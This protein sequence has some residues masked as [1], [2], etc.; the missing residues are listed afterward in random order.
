MRKVKKLIALL[1][2]VSTCFALSAPCFAA[3]NSMINAAALKTTE[4]AGVFETYDG[5]YVMESNGEY[6]LMKK[7]SIALTN[8]VAVNHILQ[9]NDLPTEVKE[10]IREKYDA[11]KEAG[12]TDDVTLT[13]YEDLGL[14]QN[15]NTRGVQDPVY[16]TYNGLE[17]KS[18]VTSWTGRNQPTVKI[19]DGKKAYNSAS[20]LI[21]IAMIGGNFVKEGSKASKILAAFSAGKTLW[22]A[23]KEVNPGI[24]KT[25]ASNDDFVELNFTYDF[26]QKFVYVYSEALDGWQHALDAEKAVIKNPYIRACYVDD[27]GY[28]GGSKVLQII[29]KVVTWESESYSDPW[30]TAHNHMFFKLIEQL[31]ATVGDYKFVFGD[32]RW[33]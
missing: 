20:T 26:Y 11:L 27:S 14:Y 7:S 9:N 15:A 25:T 33:E 24:I 2:A 19:Y 8:E 28:S 13:L 17:M 23:Y 1:L 29:G 30:Q 3:D 21:D 16:K 5:K 6:F 32:F 18:I 10:N 22:Q 4:T 12:L 31:D